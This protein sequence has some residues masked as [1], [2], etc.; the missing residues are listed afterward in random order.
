MFQLSSLTLLV[1]L[2]ATSQQDEE[3]F[4]IEQDYDRRS[5]RAAAR[6][7]FDVFDHPEMLDAEEAERLK[8]VLP[9]D[10]VLGVAHN[11]EAKAYPLVVMGAHELGN[12]SIGGLPIAPSW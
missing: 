4:D 10:I 12:D 9:A 6:D 7:A 1:S 3:E 8:I 2:A 5:S 11:G